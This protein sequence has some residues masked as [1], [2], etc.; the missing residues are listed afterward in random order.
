M[1]S[2]GTL[3]VVV[4]GGGPAGLATALA[5]LDLGHT[6]T[7]IERS[8]YDDVRVGEHLTPDAV[9]DLVGLSVLDVIGRDEHHRCPGV[10]S[11]W[12]SPD[13]VAQDYIFSP[14]GDGLN[15]SRPAFDR[16]LAEEVKRRGAAVHTATRLVNLK[17]DGGAWDVTL[18]R[19]GNRWKLRAAYLV[20]AT[21]RT[22]GVARKLG[23]RPIVIDSLC[24][25]AGFMSP[26]P[27]GSRQGASILVEACESG[28]WYSAL[29]SDGRLVAVYMTDADFISGSAAGSR[30]FWLQRVE[31][32]VFTKA[33]IR[34]FQPV[35]EVETQ[36]AQSQRLDRIVGPGWLAVGDAATS[37]DPLSSAGIAKA[38]R[39]G[40]R[41]ARAIHAV[42]QGSENASEDYE[43][44]VKEEFDSYLSVRAEYYRM[45]AKGRTSAF[46][47]RRYRTPPDAVPIALDPIVAVVARHSVEAE[48]ARLFL[49]EWV[50]D[51]DGEL[52]FSLAQSPQPAHRLVE[53]FERRSRRRS[54]SRDVI[55]AVQLLLDRNFLVRAESRSD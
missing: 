52:L 36:P 2:P 18:G 46:W 34:D 11:A 48:T 41:A 40:R 26:V 8:G 7:L 35:S 23:C 38:L 9:P 45:G 5:L 31:D 54:R 1:T 15:L 22:C 19:K 33:R 42:A 10:Q 14:Y 43:R 39:S 29:L 25:L 53:S 16:T 47:R 51:V 50:P 30:Q 27:G 17:H 32:S 21:G 6:V 55:I 24:G 4:I 37:F 3:H 13:I 20:D 28:W 12:G 44:E 49:A